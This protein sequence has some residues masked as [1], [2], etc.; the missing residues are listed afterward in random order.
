MAAS[1]GLEMMC[2]HIEGRHEDYEIDTLWCETRAAEWLGPIGLDRPAAFLAH[3]ETL[4][5]PIFSRIHPLSRFT[6]LHRDPV[7]I[8]QS[9]YSKNQWGMSQYIS[10]CYYD[11]YPFRYQRV[12]CSDEYQLAWYI[13]FTEEF[14][15]AFGRFVGD[16]FVEISADKLFQQDKEEIDKLRNFTELNLSHNIVKKHFTKKINEKAHKV[17]MSQLWLDIATEKFRK[18]YGEL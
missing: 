8:F 15:R 14:S 9:F 12:T 10:P 17:K 3:T 6:Y 1:M 2:R 16:R 18:H 7:K 11:L 5:A 13:K 4:F